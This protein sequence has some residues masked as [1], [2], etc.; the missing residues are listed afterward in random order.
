MAAA[1]CIFVQYVQCH[2]SCHLTT[3][4]LL[5]HEG[6]SMILEQL[7][8]NKNK[9]RCLITGWEWETSMLSIHNVTLNTILQLMVVVGII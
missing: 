1:Y 5:L 4:L 2:K 6:C 8:Q 3:D 7:T 9:T